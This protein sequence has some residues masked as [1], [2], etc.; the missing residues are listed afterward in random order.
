MIG[1]VRRRIAGDQGGFTVVEL[2]LSL[3]VSALIFGSLVSVIYSFSQSAGDSGRRAD[4]QQRGRELVADMVV[5]LRQAEA[6][7]ANG[8]PIESISD[9]RLVF[10]SDRLDT[11]GPERVVYERKGCS[12]GLCELWIT[13]YAAEPGTGPEWQFQT[14]PM[15]DG[16]VIERVQEDQPLFSGIEW[17]GDPPSKVYT[18]SCGGAGPE[19]DFPLVAITFRANPVGTSAGADDTFE[20]EEEVRL[21]N[22]RPA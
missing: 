7:T 19:C 4:L 14:T 1:A 22:D 11:E 10:Y 3:L 6:V 12:G 8:F 18:S 20:I 21:R 16:A 17:L 13:R 15:E 5:E 9:S 2:A